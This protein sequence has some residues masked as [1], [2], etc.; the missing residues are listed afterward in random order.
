[1]PFSLLPGVMAGSL[2]ELTPGM[3]AQRGIRL[4]ML[5]FDNTIVPYTTDVPTGEMLS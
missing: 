3:L 2:T 1:M 5:D 4:L